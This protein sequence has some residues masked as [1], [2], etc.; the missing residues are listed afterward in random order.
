LSPFS[1]EY[2]GV[3]LN[4]TI[5][6]Y[7]FAFLSPREDGAVSFVADDLGKKEFFADPDDVG[8]SRLLLHRGVYDRI[9]RD[10]NGG[11]RI[12][13]TVTTSVDTPMGS[14]LGTSSALVVALIEA[15]RLLL[16]LPLGVYD[17][18]HLAWEIERVDL[19]LSGGKQDQ[20]AAAFGGINFV[21]FLS[22]DRVVVNPLQVPSAFLRELESSMVIAFSGQSR[23]SAD[24]IDQQTVGM[25]THK[26][27]TL[28]AL[29]EL[30]SDAI[31]MKAALLRGRIDTMAS[32]LQRSWISKKAT[33]NSVSTPRI[34][35][36][37][38]IAMKNGALAGKV[39]GAGGG[40]FLMFFVLPEDRHRLVNVLHSAGV[41]ANP[42]NFTHHGCQSW[43]KKV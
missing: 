32:I 40:G 3:I 25:T 42:V 30:K 7:A 23:K 1:E 28:D 4:C 14:G 27:K 26:A 16:D 34:E 20:Y 39:S 19:G 9:M 35:E 37:Y 10:Y 13:M 18:A 22:N 36:L 17:I 12:P 21:E 6:R 38:S 31:D 33:A 2:G 8:Q 11:E 5:D 24:I 41:Q 15:F 43:Q 29:L